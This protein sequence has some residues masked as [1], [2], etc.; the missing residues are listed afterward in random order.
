M[1][2]YFFLLVGWPVVFCVFLPDISVM[3][4]VAIFITQHNTAHS[5]WGQ[6]T[7]KQ[8]LRN[9]LHFWRSLVTTYTKGEGG[10][11]PWLKS[12]GSDLRGRQ[13]ECLSSPPFAVG[14][15]FDPSWTCMV[16]QSQMGSSDWLES[17][18]E[19]ML[20]FTVPSE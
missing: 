19:N 18:R 5:P 17:R 12:A 20:C 4:Y 3:F 2:F 6:H 10:A 13:Q 16:N 7:A 8:Q 9:A 15:L 1:I 14:L 11:W